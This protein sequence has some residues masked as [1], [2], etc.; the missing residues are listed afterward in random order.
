MTS[1]GILVGLHPSWVCVRVVRHAKTGFPPLFRKPE[2]G[3]WLT[4]ICSRSIWAMSLSRLSGSLAIFS[5]WADYAATLMDTQPL[6][7]ICSGTP[8]SYLCLKMLS[9]GLTI[10]TLQI[11]RATHGHMHRVKRT[12]GDKSRIRG[13]TM[14]VTPPCS[15]PRFLRSLRRIVTLS[16]TNSS[17]IANN[18]RGSHINPRRVRTS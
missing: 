12:K 3:C 8:W 16:N 17:S 13:L 6:T 14:H 11:L 2:Q 7:T 15:K 4:C 1:I 9:K 10:A 18:K 5:A